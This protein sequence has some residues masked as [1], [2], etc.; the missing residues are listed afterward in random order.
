[1]KMI[2]KLC[3]VLVLLG[4][5]EAKTVQPITQQDVDAVR[6]PS[7]EIKSQ[8]AALLPRAVRDNR[9]LEARALEVG[10]PLNEDGIALARKLGV[11]HPE[12]VRIVVVKK[13]S[14]VN[15][16][17]RLVAQQP[18]FS[19][20]AVIAGITAGYGIFLD[21]QYADKLWVLAHELVHVGQYEREG[22]EGLIERVITEQLALPGR[23]IPVE[24]EAI[25]LS[26]K[27]L[28]IDPPDYAF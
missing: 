4:G 14:K 20:G 9:M 27:V 8:V 21:D 18:M 22:F 10:R 17:D 25:E 11:A 3:L 26:S 2:W 7:P 28:R 13:I 12:K 16:A 24:R 19:A 15:T 23:L 5:C 6:D 1:M